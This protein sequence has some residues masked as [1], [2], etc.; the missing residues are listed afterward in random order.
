M[1]AQSIHSSEVVLV[2]VEISLGTTGHHTWLVG[3]FVGEHL[4]PKEAPAYLLSYHY[5]SSAVASPFDDVSSHSKTCPSLSAASCFHSPT[6]L[7]HS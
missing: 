3:T 1:V 2:A 7:H 6:G 4:Q 5:A